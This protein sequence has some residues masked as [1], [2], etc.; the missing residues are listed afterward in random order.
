MTSEISRLTPDIGPRV[1]AKFGG[2]SRLMEITGL[3]FQTIDYWEKSGNIPEKWRPWL[4]A[5]AQRHGVD[6]TPYDYIAY[7]LD[8]RIAA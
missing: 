1:I 4:L 3:T 2:K 6:H 7:M 8:I 5:L